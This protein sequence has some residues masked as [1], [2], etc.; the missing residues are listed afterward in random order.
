MRLSLGIIAGLV[1][2]LTTGAA[3]APATT[4]TVSKG[5]VLAIPPATVRALGIK[6]KRGQLVCVQFPKPPLSALP[7]PKVAGKG[8]HGGHDHEHAPDP[9]S[10]RSPKIY[11]GLANDGGLRIQ[12][13]QAYTATGPIPGKP[14]TK[15]RAVYQKGILVL[16]PAG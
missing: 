14:G 9:R 4:L 11:T 16:S 12:K 5:G 6:Q 15:Y 10:I 1:G 2:L 3:A 8:E 13:V 7:K